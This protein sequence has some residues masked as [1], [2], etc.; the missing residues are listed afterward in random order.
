VIEVAARRF[1]TQ[2][3]FKQKGRA[4]IDGALLKDGNDG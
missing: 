1:C 3:V 4:A 2:I